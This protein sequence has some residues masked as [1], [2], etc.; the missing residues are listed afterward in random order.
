MHLYSITSQLLQ[1][2]HL[3][4][5]HSLMLML[6]ASKQ[7][8]QYFDRQ[9]GHVSM[10]IAHTAHCFSLQKAHW[11]TKQSSHMRCSHAPHSSSVGGPI[12]LTHASQRATPQRTAA[13]GGFG[14]SRSTSQRN[15]AGRHSWQKSEPQVSQATSSEQPAS[16]RCW[17]SLCRK[18]HR[19]TVQRLQRFWA[20]RCAT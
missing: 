17:I 5:R 1:S 4:D 2:L 13:N 11:S 18:L 7:P 6:T 14:S 20:G 12:S 15:K 8:R 3:Q 9:R 16:Q 19:T 10:L